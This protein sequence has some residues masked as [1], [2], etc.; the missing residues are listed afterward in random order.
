[1]ATEAAQ[2][3]STVPAQAGRE[4]VRR[5]Q[6]ADG[7][8]YADLCGLFGAA[9]HRYAASRLMGDRELAEEMVAETLMEAVRNIRRFDPRKASLS[10]W[11]YGIA[12]HHLQ[13]QC[14]S[15][16]RKRSVPPQSQVPLDAIA[17]L[18]DDSPMEGA[19]GRRLDAQRQLGRLSVVLSED[20]M[21]LLMLSYGQ[22]F[23]AGEIGRIVGRSA[24]AVETMLHRAKQKARACLG[25]ADG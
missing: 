12:R 21:E 16:R 3:E 10:A 14:R 24:R 4:L 15:Q 23:T 8:A 5:L 19:V 18:A 25:N 2:P 11:L 22:E 13:A 6:Q 1:M 20:E 7:A 17:E 9:L